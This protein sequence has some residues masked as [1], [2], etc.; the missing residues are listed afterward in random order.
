M[1][2]QSDAEMPK[3]KEN[4]IEL[5]GENVK[6]VDGESGDRDEALAPSK[7]RARSEQ[8]PATSTRKRH[9]RRKQGKLG[10]LMNLPIEIFTEIACLL[11]PG[12]L[13]ALSRSNKFFHNMLLQRSS[14]QMWRHAES[15]M[16]EMPPCLP[17]MCEPQYAALIF[18]K[19]C[20]LC[21]ASA[22]AKPDAG[23]GIRLCQSCRDTK[24]M[25]LNLKRDPVINLV[26]HSNCIRPKRAESQPR[27][28]RN[29]VFSLKHEVEEVYKRQMDFRNAGDE[30]GLAQWE[31]DRRAEVLARGKHA[32]ELRRYLDKMV[33]MRDDEL[34]IIKAQRRET[35]TERLKAL[36]WAEKDINF[37]GL[38]ETEWRSLVEAPKPLTD[39]MWKNLLPKL[40]GIM[41]KNREWKI[42][43]DR[44]TRQIE[45]RDCI[46]RF[47]REMKRTGHPFQCIIEVLG[48]APALTFNSDG[49][50]V[51]ALPKSQ[52]ELTNPFPKAHTALKW[53]CL[54]DLPEVEMTIEELGA[55]LEER[56]AGIEVKVAEWRVAVEQQLVDKLDLGVNA[57]D[58]ATLVVKGSTD[59]TAHLSHNARILLRA[60]SVFKRVNLDPHS[61]PRSSY[62]PRYY[63]DIITPSTSFLANFGLETNLDEYERAVEA[64]R[65]I[66]A[67]LGQLGMPNITLAEL[68]LGNHWFFCERCIDRKPKTWK[69]LVE[70]YIV[71]HKFW[72]EQK[73]IQSKYPV[74]H[75]I[76]YRNV[77]DPES[78]DISKPLVRLYEE[79]EIDQLLARVNS[80]PTGDPKSR[81][82]CHICRCTGRT[83]VRLTQ[84]D[85]LVHLQDVHG[86]TEALEG[87]HYGMECYLS[88][89]DKWH[90]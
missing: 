55:R 1:V 80:A 24:L 65:I 74:R 9:V 22:T 52:F 28:S 15:N 27:L 87:L 89:G 40:T 10:G 31:Q 33:W 82:R 81:P 68:E 2:N 23:L 60:D 18:S 73:D 66:K 32:P 90:R 51:P 71:Q 34:V 35:I 58:E 42:E 59:L 69:G 38:G 7:K 47:L 79:G 21:G 39:R 45:R 30:K 3:L 44:H 64:E 20:T 88:Q 76:L 13:L 49:P 41:E 4:E 57:P 62:A 78:A 29:S 50:K 75:P 25:E 67:L 85:M 53:D 12:D 70:H 36:G 48:V 37:H 77:H 11:N 14:V 54:N 5:A 17:G 56:R 43:C 16:P 84:G 8:E 6:P 61:N 86:V 26:F 63:P 19:Y 46:G 83:G 72:N